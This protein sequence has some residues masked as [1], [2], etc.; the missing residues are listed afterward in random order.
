MI[1]CFQ[2]IHSV[3][4]MGIYDQNKSISV[5]FPVYRQTTLSWLIKT[6]HCFILIRA[7]LYLIIIPVCCYDNTPGVF[8]EKVHY[9]KEA[10]SFGGGPSLPIFSWFEGFCLE[11]KDFLHFR[12]R[13]ISIVVI[14]RITFWFGKRPPPFF[15]R[16]LQ[17]VFYC[18]FTL[19]TRRR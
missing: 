15:K 11:V 14:K 7:A 13:R 17:V 12:L 2:A 6:T 19:I 5:S 16:A 18:W 10:T 3:K 1:S 4:P 9:Q 8:L